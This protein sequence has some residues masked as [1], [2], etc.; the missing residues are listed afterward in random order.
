[1][2][3]YV[4]SL[5]ILEILCLLFLVLIFKWWHLRSLMA[6]LQFLMLVFIWQVK[7]LPFKRKKIL[8]VWF[9]WLCLNEH[10]F[11]ISLPFK[12]FN[13]EIFFE[14]LTRKLFLS[15]CDVNSFPQSFEKT[16]HGWNL[17]NL[18]NFLFLQWKSFQT[19]SFKFYHPSK[20]ETFQT[21]DILHS[22]IEL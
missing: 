18:F 14:K 19:L 7:W 13:L 11:S 12:D 4:E 21:L 20:K 3:F 15:M 5:G 10:E 6:I 8:N 9:S 17:E 2:K 1:M 16:F 22:F